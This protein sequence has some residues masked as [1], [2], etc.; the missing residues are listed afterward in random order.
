MTLETDLTDLAA[1]HARGV[2]VVD[3]REPNGRPVTSGARP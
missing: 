2:S 1:A 3:V